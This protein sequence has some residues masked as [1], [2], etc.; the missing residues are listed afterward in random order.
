SVGVPAH[1][2]GAPAA[3]VPGRLAVSWLEQRLSESVS[4]AERVID[5]LRA[6]Y[7]MA[8]AGPMPAASDGVEYVEMVQQR[9]CAS[10]PCFSHCWDACANASF[11]D[12]LAF[13]EAAEAAGQAQPEMMSASLRQR[14]IQP[15][16]LTG[17]VGDAARIMG[18]LRAAGQRSQAE[19]RRLVTQ[20][21][22]TQKVLHDVIRIAS[23]HFQSFDEEAAE[24]LARHLAR[25]GTPAREVVVA[26]SGARREVMV[27]RVGP[28]RAP[29]SCARS[30]TQLAAQAEGVLWEVSRM[31]CR[32]GLSRPGG[33]GCEVHL[34]RRA[35]WEVSCA[36]ASRTRAGET[37]SGD[38][39][40]RVTLGPALTCV[41]L[42]D[43]MGSG[44]DAAQ[45]SE[46]AVRLAEAALAAGAGAASAIAI[47]NA[48]L[49]ARSPDERFATL[50]VAVFDLASGELE[51]AKAG[52][53]PTFLYR[54]GRVELIEGQ[55]L[56]A[57]IVAGVEA[58][59]VQRSLLDGDVVL[60]ATDGAAELGEAGEACLQ[61]VLLSAGAGA[62]PA[63]QLAQRLVGCLEA[64]AGGRWPDDLTLAVLS[65]R[66]LDVAGVPAYTGDGF[67]RPVRAAAPTGR[68]SQRRLAAS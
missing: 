53:Y 29:E 54:G 20:V 41:I 17:A 31:A 35:L 6:A 15:V 33:H 8:A 25:A 52:A 65:V 59:V 9:A 3:A 14:C 46:T 4:G 24:R 37:C 40:A 36:F 66:Q 62:S 64:V 45:E 28:C 12:V 60:M 55:A 39:F 19:A 57:G 44:P 5:A 63:D 23:G 68:Q 43:G 51:L 16:R 32:H 21:E 50:D 61:Q 48:V 30:L 38:S 47:A 11:H 26:G 67:R 27:E 7:E 22:V 13:L 58:E 1:P 18:V 42:S 2:G 49:L 56:P 10:C 34:V